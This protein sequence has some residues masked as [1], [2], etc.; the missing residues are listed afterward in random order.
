M[1]SKI[2]PRICNVIDIEIEHTSLKGEKVGNK[3][4]TKYWN[5]GV[6]YGHKG[7]VQNGI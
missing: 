2:K 6:G 5:S 4:K 1:I 7:R 3:K